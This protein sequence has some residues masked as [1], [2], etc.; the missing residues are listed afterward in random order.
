MNTYRILE[1]L[2]KEPIVSAT[3]ANVKQIILSPSEKTKQSIQ[4]SLLAT[5]NEN[6]SIA[7]NI[8]KLIT[9]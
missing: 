6:L 5:K 2:K 9:P 7:T 4:S 8:P 1:P 3:Q